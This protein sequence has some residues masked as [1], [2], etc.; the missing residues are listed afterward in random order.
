MNI[1]DRRSK[2][3]PAFEIWRPFFKK[4]GHSLFVVFGLP[5]QGLY[6]RLHLDHLCLVGT[7]YLLTFIR[8]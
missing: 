1:S 3:L 6:F 4:G 7:A 5:E 8:H 2:R